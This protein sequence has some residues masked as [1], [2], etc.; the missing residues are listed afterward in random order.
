MARYVNLDDIFET[1]LHNWGYYGL[2]EDLNNLPT[3][4]VAEAKHG[5]WKHTVEFGHIAKHHYWNCSLCGAGS[6]DCGRENY[7]PNCG[8]KMDGKGEAE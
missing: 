5:E 1:L 4:D 6:S 3:A 8:A 2:E 7:C